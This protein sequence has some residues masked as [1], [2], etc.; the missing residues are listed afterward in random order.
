MTTLKV[1]IPARSATNDANA[2]FLDGCEILWVVSW[3]D[4]GTVEG[5]LNN[6]WRYLLEKSKIADVFLVFDRYY[7]ESIK[8]LTRKYR[9]YGASLIVQDLVRNPETF[10]GK[11]KLIVT[12]QDPVPLE[13]YNDYVPI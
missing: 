5:Y 7:D 10:H 11:H 9:D 13:I 3:P 12:G 6:F 4:K 2:I 1:E 8:C